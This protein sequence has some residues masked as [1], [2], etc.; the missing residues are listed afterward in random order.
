VAAM[1]GDTIVD[2]V[3]SIC[4][5]AT[6]GLVE[7]QDWQSFDLQPT[8]NIDRV[9]R[10]PPM[11]SQGTFGQFGFSEDR[12]DSLQIWVALR[13][14]GQIDETRTAAMRYVHSLTAA[15]VRDAAEDSGD[16]AVLDEGRGH[17][18]VS[19]PARE[20]VMVRLTLP[21]NYESQL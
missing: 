16:Y 1:T 13:H 6:F 17:S 14:T 19:D 2:R 12:T 5:G 3:R 7:A 15:C 21:V 8:Q 4:L 10:I 20:Y 9:F 11:S 18:I